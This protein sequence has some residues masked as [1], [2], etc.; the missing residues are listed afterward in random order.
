MRIEYRVLVASSLI[1]EEQA[2]EHGACGWVLQCIHEQDEKLYYYFQR[3][4]L[5]S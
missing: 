1:S 3:S 2:N 4:T 5:D